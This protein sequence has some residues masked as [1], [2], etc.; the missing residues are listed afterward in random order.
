MEENTEI[1]SADGILSESESTLNKKLL[2][3]IAIVYLSS[4][5]HSLLQRCLPERLYRGD[6]G[7]A[8]ILGM[9]GGEISRHYLPEV[10]VKNLL[11][12][13][14]ILFKLMLLP[15]VFYETIFNNE[16]Q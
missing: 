15:P 10:E 13:Q 12:G 8:L 16:G 7:I 4:Y 6:L 14:A 11:Y 3:L 1:S 9:V 2:F 5:L